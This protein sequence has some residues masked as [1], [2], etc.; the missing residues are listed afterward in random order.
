MFGARASAGGFTLIEMLITL[1]LIAILLGF[2][3]PSFVNLIR[4]NE[5]TDQANSVL[6]GIVFAREQATNMGIGVSICGSSDQKTCDGQWGEGW[7]VFKDP[8][9]DITGTVS[10]TKVL[11]LEKGNSSIDASSGGA[12][13]FDSEGI[14]RPTTASASTVTIKR[15]DC[16][17]EGS[18]VISIIAGGRA[19]IGSGPC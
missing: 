4:N 16:G 17:V 10:T 11:R 6:G 13:R 12:V 9:G 3:M 19:S 15:S 1:V 7:L 14:R 8:N 5:M 18:R 2:G